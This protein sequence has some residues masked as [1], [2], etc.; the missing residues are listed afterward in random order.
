MWSSSFY[1]GSFF[2]PTF[3]GILVDRLTYDWMT[4]IFWSVYCCMVVS[5]C[6]EFGYLWRVTRFEAKPGYLTIEGAAL[7]V[8]K[9]SV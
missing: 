1:F 6:V 2:G 7:T 8:K 3:A 4:V 9:A 5:D